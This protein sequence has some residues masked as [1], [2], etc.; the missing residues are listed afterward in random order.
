MSQS[1]L[2][3]VYTLKINIALLEDIFL[4]LSFHAAKTCMD[5]LFE[6]SKPLM[7]S[8]QNTKDFGYQEQNIFYYTNL[9]IHGN[10]WLE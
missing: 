4:E 10:L 7:C 6:V 1:R 5:H 8:C 9:F 2:T 3:K